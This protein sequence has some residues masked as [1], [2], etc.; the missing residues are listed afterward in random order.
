MSTVMTPEEFHTWSQ[1]L[2]LSKETEALIAA[3]RSSPPVRRVRGRA[4]NVTGRYPS[5]KMGRSIQ[6]ESQHVELW[7][8]Y[9]MERDDDVLEFYDQSSRIPLAY[10]AR[11]GHKTT[12][13]HTPDF[14]VLRKS[15]AGWEEW[16][17]ASMLDELAV[18][19]PARYQQ[20]GSGQW[21]CPPGEAYA[22]QFGLTYRL[23]SSAEYHPLEIQNLK[24]LQDFWAHDVPP[25]SE[26]EALALT[27]IKAHPGIRL[28]ELLSI[29]PDLSVDILWTLISQR[30][31]FTDLSATLLMAHEQVMLYG[32]ETEVDQARRALELPS[33]LLPQYGELSWDGRLWQVEAMTDPVRL[34][35][36]VGEPLLLSLTEFQH[37]RKVGLMW[38]V[39]EVSP[40]PT[41][42][43]IREALLHASPKAQ[44]EANRRLREML[45]YAR[46]EPVTT[47]LRSVRRWWHAYQEA[48]TRFR[49]GYLGLLD[50]VAQRGNRTPRIPEAS[51]QLLEAH[52]QTHYAAPQAKSAAAVYRLYREQ[53]EQQGLPPVSERTFYRVRA[54]FITTDVIAARQGRRAAYAAQQFY[55]LDQTTPRHGERPF[56]LAH[57]DHTE[58]DIELISS[59]TGKP[60]G[61][62]WATFLTDAYSRR[63]LA[64]YVTYDPPSYRSV[65]MAFR[66]CVRRHQRLPQ[67]CFVDR[68]PEFGSVYFETLLTR[69]FVTKKDRP[70]SQPRMG[71]VIERLFGTTTTQLLHQ[72]LG[73]TQASK[74]PRLLTRE[75]E[76]RRLAVWTLER[77][78]ARLCQYAYEVYDQMDH[79]ALGQSPREAFAQGMQLAGLRT[80]RLIP[81]SEEFLLLTCPTTRTG[82]A[83]VDRARGIAVNG[84]RYWNPLMRTSRD[85]GKSVPVRYEPFDM[86]R[87]YAFLDGQWLPCTADAFFQVQGRSEREWQLILD[88]WR[89]QQRQHSRKRV[90]VNGPLL[91]RFLEEIATEEQLLLQ[92]QRDLEGLLIREAIV[93]RS[94]VRLKEPGAEAEVGDEELDLATLPQYEEYR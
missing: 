53:C 59:V 90:S 24:F 45:A 66:E 18:S 16:K 42:P 43:E 69:H 60:L 35:P 89:E 77:F 62:P 20:A 26:Q 27:H 8:I 39:D 6:F 9:G 23:R 75:V 87:A 50:R 5:P 17:P 40:S 57:L 52:L 37:L 31:V 86:S 19:M 73:N 10:R 88:E 11:S 71:S 80:H 58:L 2:Q 72:L 91:A 55:W 36:E 68:G 93:G 13:W 63:I 44:Q 84:L 15:S 22:A 33:A 4:N 83:K 92:Q 74:Q 64:C 14:F 47:S 41:T 48:E 12:Q 28:S 34:R 79:P 78:S 85:A 76:P 54:R 65:M 30:R 70:A 46:G 49:C 7:A 32:E 81:Y 3:I 21:C 25:H 82:Y 1:H 94:I 38:E 29:Y 67:E 61:K 51:M 56:A